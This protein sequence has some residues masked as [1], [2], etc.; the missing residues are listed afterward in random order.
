MH[1]FSVRTLALLCACSLSIGSHYASYILGPLKSRLARE[2]GTSN[3]EFSLLISALSLNS[4]WTPLVGGLMASRLGT[5][6]TSLIATSLILVGQAVLLVGDIME[7]VR[8]MTFGMFI[9]GLGVSPLA[10]VQESIIVRF[11]KNHGLGLSM[12]FGLVVGKFSS[13]ISARTSYPLSEHFGPRAPFVVATLLAA[14][15]FIMNLVYISVS[16]WLISS[17]GVEL[18]AAELHHEARSRLTESVSEA[19]ALTEVA[20]KKTVH[21]SDVAKLGDVFWAYIG[22]NVIC[23]AIWHPFVHLAPN[24][25]ERRYHLTELEAST[26]SSYLL[27][28]ST[29]LYPICGFIIDRLKRGPTLHMMFVVS[30]I[31]TFFCYAWL[32]LPPNTTHTP[33]PA[34]ISYAVGQG[35]APLL[36]VILVP[37]LVPSKY[38]PTTLGAHKS[39]EQ[40]GSTIFQ[41]LAGI[42]LD[43]HQSGETA[44]DHA[45]QAGYQPL[46]VAFGMLNL[47]QLFGIMGLWSLDRSRKRQVARLHDDDEY[48][49][50]N[51]GGRPGHGHTPAISESHSLQCRDSMVFPETPSFTPRSGEQPDPP[52]TTM[53]EEALP[54][55]SSNDSD[56]SAIATPS[57]DGDLD[58]LD[59]FQSGLARST[60]EVQ[61]GHIFAALSLVL[62]TSA[63]M[64]FIGTAL[65]K[66]RS[67]SDRKGEPTVRGI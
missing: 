21:I 19:Q 12:A 24:I 20:A 35:F 47:V 3:T 55:L 6:M 61:R 46:L 57:Q 45:K 66:L 33:I 26:V 29:F 16:K 15:S 41:T 5:T 9:F 2:M 25:I 11:F 52:D 37:T 7:S 10:V 59:E 56:L 43:T 62:I 17:S 18:E 36:L 1:V 4:T 39:L 63:W 40:T 28:G 38:I 44:P 31:L 60:T 54:L 14:L 13:F 49:E 23:G 67:S 32:S 22:I 27:V 50:P 42:L 8:I 51:T 65:L 48:D 58:V 34:I 30:S 64:L 53:E